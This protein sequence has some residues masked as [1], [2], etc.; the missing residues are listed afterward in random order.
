MKNLKSFA[1]RHLFGISF[2]L[3][4]ILVVLGV[5]LGKQNPSWYLLIALA[6]LVYGP[7]FFSLSWEW[8]CT[9]CGDNEIL[10]RHKFCSACGGLMGLKKKEKRFCSRSHRVSKYDRFCPK[11]G[12]SLI[13][14][15][16]R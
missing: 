2:S 1:T 4:L 3:A 8:V 13:T 16:M 5:F 12:V 15:R 6:V 9:K 14:G 10:G 11:C 7:I